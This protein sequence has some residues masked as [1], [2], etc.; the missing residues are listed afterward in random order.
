MLFYNYMLQ[1]ILEPNRN[2][3]RIMTVSVNK[4]RDNFLPKMFEKINKKIKNGPITYSKTNIVTQK[5]SASTHVPGKNNDP[6]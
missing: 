6:F 1:L 2:K 4:Q 3:S 5:I